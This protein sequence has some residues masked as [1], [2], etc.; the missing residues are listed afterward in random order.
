MKLIFDKQGNL[1]ITTSGDIPSS[2]NTK[3]YVIVDLMEDEQFDFRYKYVINEDGFATKG[4][5]KEIDH[6]EVARI[7]NEQE[8]IKYQKDRASEYPS[9]GNQLDMLWHAMNNGEIPKANT[10]FDAIETVKT[11]FPKPQ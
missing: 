9:I 10:F 3:D 2:H 8:A 5:L 1:L 7:D 6:E 11:S 4:E